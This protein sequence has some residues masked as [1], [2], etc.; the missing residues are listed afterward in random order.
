MKKTFVRIC[1]AILVLCMVSSLPTFAASAT[2][3]PESESVLRASEYISSFAIDVTREWNGQLAITFSV[4]GTG[5]MSRIGAKSIEISEKVGNSW[6]EVVSYDQYDSG[7]SKTNT[8]T[9]ANTIFFNGEIGTKYRIVVTIFSQGST[10]SDSETE[11]FIVTA[12]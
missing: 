9:Y 3:R 7:M 1:A 6:N 10:G 12:V 2:N 4:I 11:T 8:V 5:R